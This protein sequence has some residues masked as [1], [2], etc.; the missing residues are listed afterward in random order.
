MRQIALVVHNV[1]SAH[2]VGSLLRTAD[3]LGVDR[4]YLSGYTPYPAA[5]NDARLPHEASKVNRRIQKTALGAEITAKWDHADDIHQI[6]NELRTQRYQIVA[7]E[8]TPEATSL[9]KFKASSNIAL[10]V[11]SEVGGLEQNILDLCDKYVQIPMSGKKES[12]NVATA[13]AM[14]LYHLRYIA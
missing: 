7:L 10:V 2:N 8:Q 6:L 1:R 11:G 12:Y 5:K 13:A 4:V 9:P 3:G 14:A